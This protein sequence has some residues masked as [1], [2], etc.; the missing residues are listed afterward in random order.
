MTARFDVAGLGN[1]I[2]DVIARVDDTFLLRHQIAKGG[3]TLIDTHR[4]KMLED[5]LSETTITPGGSAANTIAGVA[6]LGGQGAFIGRVND[7]W[8]GEG[9][10]GGT[11]A[12]GVHYETPFARDGAPTARSVILVTPDGQR[13]MNTYLGASVE[14]DEGDIDEALIAASKILYIEGYLWDSDRLKGAVRKAI[15]AAR[16]ADTLTAFTCSDSFCVGR[17][18]SE[19]IDLIETEIDIVFANEAELMALYETETFDA[20]FQQA[21]ATGKLFAITRSEKGAVITQGQAVHIIDAMPGVEVIDTTG[22]GDQ[23]AA[24]FLTGLSRGLP[25]DVSGRLGVLAAGEV[26]SHIGPRPQ[27]TLKDLAKAAGLI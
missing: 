11:K 27:V 22:A 7:D 9:F 19:F 25:L 18:R 24:G 23:F 4:A 13:S 15:A 5:A 12:I 17:F 21:R 16:K 20:A 8:L 26:I 6:S 1:A 3:M 2:V 14:M 10:S